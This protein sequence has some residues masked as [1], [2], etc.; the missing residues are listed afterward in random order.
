MAQS[1][2]FS[3]CLKWKG[4]PIEMIVFEQSRKLLFQCGLRIDANQ[5]PKTKLCNLFNRLMVFLSTSFYFT[6]SILIIAVNF[7][8]MDSFQLVYCVLQAQWTFISIALFFVLLGIQHDIREML[9]T[10]Q[11]TVDESALGLKLLAF[12]HFPFR[13]SL[14]EWRTVWEGR[15]SM[16]KPNGTCSPYH[17][18]PNLC[19]NSAI[20]Q[21]RSFRA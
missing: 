9:Q 10:L 20:W 6:S 14:Q 12:F 7:N 11:H 18:G 16:R 21:C 5:S 15:R 19:C 17:D 3:I 2:C 13:V 8:A 1:E 4:S